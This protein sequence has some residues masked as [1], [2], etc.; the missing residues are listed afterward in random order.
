MHKYLLISLTVLSIFLFNCDYQRPSPNPLNMVDD[1]T[2][3]PLSEMK[4]DENLMMLVFGEDDVLV[5]INGEDR[6]EIPIKSLTKRVIEEATDKEINIIT[7]TNRVIETLK[8]EYGAKKGISS[9]NYVKTV[10]EEIPDSAILKT[11]DTEE[12]VVL[13]D[14]IM[15]GKTPVEIPVPETEETQ[16]T[17]EEEK[18]QEDVEI[19]T[20]ETQE[21]TDTETDTDTEQQEIQVQDDQN[22][23]QQG[24]QN[25]DQQQQQETQEQGDQNQQEQGDPNQQQQGDPIQQ[26][27]GDQNQ[28]IQ[29]NNVPAFTEGTSTTRAVAENTDP[30]ENIGSP[31]AATDA[32]IDTLTY[33]LGGTDASSFGIDSTNGQLQTSAALDYENKNS[34]TVTI[35]VS[36]GNGGTNSIIVMINITDVDE[37][38]NYPP[39]QTI[40]V[41]EEPPFVPP[42]PPQNSPQQEVNNDPA[43]TEGTSTTRAVA[44]NTASGENIGSAVSATDADT[45]TLTYTLGGT[46][47]SSFSIASSSGQ[48]QTK[49]ALNYESKNSYA[50]TVSVSDGK[51]GT[52]SITV[53]I[54]ITDVDETPNDPPQ[55]NVITPNPV[56]SNTNTQSATQNV[57]SADY[58]LVNLSNPDNIDIRLLFHTDDDGAIMVTNPNRGVNIAR[59]YPPALEQPEN[60][61]KLAEWTTNYQYKVTGTDSNNFKISQI[62]DNGYATLNIKNS[63][64]NR[65]YSIIVSVQTE[66]I[67]K[68]RDKT[69]AE[70]EADIVFESGHQQAANNPPIFTDGLT[71]TRSVKEGTRGSRTI[72][73]PISATDADGDTL[74]YSISGT[75]ASLFDIDTN[76]GLLLTRHNVNLV[77]ATKR[78]YLVTVS[79]SDGRGSSDSISVK[80]NLI[81]VIVEAPPVPVTINVTVPASTTLEGQ[82]VN[83]SNPNYTINLPYQNLFDGTG[84]TIPLASIKTTG[85]VSYTTIYKYTMSDSVANSGDS[86]HF[87]LI[88]STAAASIKSYRDAHEENN[89]DVSSIKRS[90]RYRLEHPE[91]KNV[92][93]L[94]NVAELHLK[95]GQLTKET[96]SLFI[97]AENTGGTFPLPPPTPDLPT[98][99]F[100]QGDTGSFSA[101]VSGKRLNDAGNPIDNT[102]LPDIS[103]VGNADQENYKYD[104][105]FA[106]SINID[107]WVWQGNP[108]ETETYEDAEF[109]RIAVQFANSFYV[110][111]APVNVDSD[112]YGKSVIPGH[113]N[114]FSYLATHHLKKP[115]ETKEITLPKGKFKKDIGKGAK[116]ETDKTVVDHKAV[117]DVEGVVLTITGGTGNPDTLSYTVKSITGPVT[118]TRET[119]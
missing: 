16:D 73:A 30:G 76:S 59:I 89:G 86:E 36:D 64:S 71:T 35:T 98:T 25:Q 69:Q 96:Y 102:S 5:N 50:V 90:H 24:D 84:I 94:S 95:T 68:V 7:I 114:I 108:F 28:Q 53:T 51:G 18:Q 1:V 12:L 17:S 3:K 88:Q 100:S 61:L 77:Y 33:S 65:S 32:D 99:A 107:G 34:Y 20:A 22:Q 101:S 45:D 39:P 54:N 14:E 29:V 103:G 93:E 85:Q 43:F 66:G 42:D 110:S 52:D 27:Q 4:E 118:I 91:N 72:G 9:E 70:I 44:E 81:E 31:V 109:I 48:L 87:E 37:T 8:E 2:M 21:E 62:G 83:G 116:S 82:Y 97:T 115:W 13:V 117:M 58:P 111:P 119:P 46:D 49:A 56:S 55:V 10:L 92:P 11:V 104:I 26:Q 60:P 113:Y 57:Q 15:A 23:Q 79:V 112:D 6:I 40:V 75:N 63:L 67:S 78:I 38:P 41:V 106:L 47:A 74:T 19:K 80:I 105:K